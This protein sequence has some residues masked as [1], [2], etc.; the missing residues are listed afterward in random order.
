MAELYT[1]HDRHVVERIVKA[2]MA[3]Y[4]CD[5]RVRDGTGGEGSGSTGRHW[6]VM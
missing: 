4:G 5:R 1:T 3:S 6:N 2:V